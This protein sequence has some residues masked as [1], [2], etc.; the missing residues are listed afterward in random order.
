M[1]AKKDGKQML[2]FGMSAKQIIDI[3]IIVENINKINEY[4]GI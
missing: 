3:M 1:K 2:I 4:N